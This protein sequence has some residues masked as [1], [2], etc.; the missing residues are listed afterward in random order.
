MTV[1][2]ASKQVEIADAD[3]ERVHAFLEARPFDPFN[4]CPE[5]PDL[6]QLIATV[7]AEERERCA[8]L[9]D[10]LQS[11]PGF[12]CAAAIREQKP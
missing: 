7:R 11:D 5:I 9:C 10:R 2:N 4:R 8:V 6:A 1:S 3:Y 12:E